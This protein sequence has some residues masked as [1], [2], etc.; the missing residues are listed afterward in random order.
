MLCLGLFCLLFG[1]NVGL[2]KSVVA[3]GWGSLGTILDDSINQESTPNESK[4]HVGMPRVIK[5]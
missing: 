1:L 4:W 5:S 2:L 3:F